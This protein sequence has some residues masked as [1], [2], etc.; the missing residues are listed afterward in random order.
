M[1]E[2]KLQ[3]L[4]NVYIRVSRSSRGKPFKYRKDFTDFD[5]SQTVY[6]HRIN[7]LLTRYKHITAEDY[8][9]AAFELNKDEDHIPLSFFS[10]MAGV[11]AYTLFKKEQLELPPDH[12]LEF[13]KES[14]KFIA[15]FCIEQKIPLNQYITHQTGLTY[16]WMKHVRAH[17]VSL[18]AL[19]EFSNLH[20]I[21]SSVPEDESYMLLEDI[22]K[23]YTVYR[24]RY[25]KAIEAPE[26][27]SK[28]IKRL[29][30]FVDNSI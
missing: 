12:Q 11:K 5:P 7:N 23:R 27:V 17:K 16:D 26:L 25:V 2:Q 14:L 15:H 24:A 6:L 4:Y 3:D 9:T 1:L 20:D 21:I 22:P 10:T 29:K 13:I 28:G 30:P 18:Y 19:M 8:F